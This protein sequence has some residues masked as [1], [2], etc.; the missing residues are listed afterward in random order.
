MQNRHRV[1]LGEGASG[2]A[3]RPSTVK[4]GLRASLCTCGFE[5]RRFRGDGQ[6]GT[7][8][9]VRSYS[10]LTTPCWRDNVAGWTYR[11]G[12][13][14]AL[15]HL[16]MRSRRAHDEA[17]SPTVRALPGLEETLGIESSGRA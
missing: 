6:D 10:L 14:L 16:S 15:D 1:V 13:R 17:R 2:A 8:R 5:L 9:T 12:L 11:S 7:Q 4:S 3:G